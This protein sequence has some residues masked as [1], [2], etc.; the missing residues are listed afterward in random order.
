M[1]HL[2]ELAILINDYRKQNNLPEIQ[3]LTAVSWKHI[4]DLTNHHPEI[5]CNGNLQ[6]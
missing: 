6:S 1:Q 5:A 3:N 4:V 2:G